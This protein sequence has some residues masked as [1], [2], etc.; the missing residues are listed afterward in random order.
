LLAPIAPAHAHA[1]TN[2][3]MTVN[4]TNE[5]ANANANA[6]AE[7][8][9]DDVM[10][11]HGEMQV[12]LELETDDGAGGPAANGSYT[13]Q[14][15]VI[16]Q[17]PVPLLLLSSSAATVAVATVTMMTDIISGAN[18]DTGKGSNNPDLRHVPCCHEEVTINSSIRMKMNPRLNVKVKE[19]KPSHAHD[20]N[21]CMRMCMNDNSIIDM[22]MNDD[23]M[24][25]YRDSNI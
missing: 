18:R 25:Y 20:E 16:V 19:E 14:L 13:L 23:T 5:D 15:P 1:N 2:V 21:I 3:T 9:Q 22:N 10:V 7:Q 6:I 24:T 8:W 4:T 17:V 12:E 11:T